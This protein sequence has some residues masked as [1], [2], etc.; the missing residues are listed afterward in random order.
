MVTDLEKS[1]ALILISCESNMELALEAFL[2]PEDLYHFLGGVFSSVE[3]QKLIAAKVS[4]ID[5]KI[6]DRSYV[7]S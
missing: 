6:H 3:T 5:M 1:L 7:R 4:L 2:A